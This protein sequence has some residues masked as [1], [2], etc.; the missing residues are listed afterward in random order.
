MEN[1]LTGNG[2]S[3]LH[4]ER[5]A[6]EK[7]KIWFF[8]NR[9]NVFGISAALIQG[10]T[11]YYAEITPV[12]LDM[13][14]EVYEEV[15]FVTNLQIQQTENATQQDV[16]EGE[17]TPT[18]KLEQPMEDPRVASAVNPF[19][20]NATQPVDL[21]PTL[22]PDYTLAA[23]QAGIE[24]MLVLSVVIADTGE[25]LQIK[26][27]YRNPEDRAKFVETGIEAE[28]I[29][30]YRMKKFSPAVMEGKPITVR[31]NIPI[32]YSLN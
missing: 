14:D 28:A 10:L 31:V 21:S 11:V 22:R 15:A 9:F 32:R 26:P 4:I 17:I 19:E 24:G 23:R 18:D 13:G 1:T 16:A 25:V 30:V 12:S 27:Q 3:N 20:V 7:F 6:S 5:S 29:R 2:I 8:Q